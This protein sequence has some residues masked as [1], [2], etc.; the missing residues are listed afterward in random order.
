VDAGSATRAWA[1]GQEYAGTTDY[2]Q[3]PGVP[4]V[5]AMTGARWTKTALPGV[6]WNGELSSVAATGPAEA[7]AAGQETGGRGHVLRWNGSAWA[8]VALPDAVATGDA[9]TLEGAP[10]YAPWLLARST[11]GA[12]TVLRWTGGEWSAVAAPAPGSFV[13]RVVDVAPDG[14][15]RLA[16]TVSTPIPGFP[17]S[18][19]ILHVHRWTGSGWEELPGDGPQ[20]FPTDLVAGPGGEL[21]VAGQVPWVGPGRPPP[22]L[23]ATLVHHDGSAWTTVPLGTGQVF[24]TPSLTGDDAGRAEYVFGTFGFGEAGPVPGVL[25]NDG[26]TWT[27]VPSAP[28][29]PPETDA[30]AILS[31]AHLPGTA[32]TVAVGYV[33][34]TYYGQYAPRIEREDR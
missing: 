15:V 7:W 16:G 18:V 6:T 19:P 32:S 21:W 22:V 25:R 26:G 5:L 30:A 29:V 31:G 33:Q 2:G 23:P 27:R 20:V 4:L 14:T 3:I 17:L 24:G 13:P 10:G 9:L 1:V 11:A 12:V 8:E 28:G 34:Y